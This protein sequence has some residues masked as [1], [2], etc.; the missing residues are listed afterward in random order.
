MR[1][2]A[3]CVTC[4]GQNHEEVCAPKALLATPTKSIR[5]GCW[6]VRTMFS[7]GKIAQI[8]KKRSPRETRRRPVERERCEM[9]FKTWTEAARIAVDRKRWKYTIKGL[10]LQVE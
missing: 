5:I 10:I 6:N 3:N 1:W 4:I 7:I 8:E 2:D 9:G